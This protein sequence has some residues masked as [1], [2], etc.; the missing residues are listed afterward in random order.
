MSDPDGK[1]QEPMKEKD[2]PYKKPEK[3]EKLS[4][5]E[6]S[7]RQSE[8]TQSPSPDKGPNASSVKEPVVKWRHTMAAEKTMKDM[9]KAAELERRLK[10]KK[11]AD[12]DK[13][14]DKA[15]ES[16]QK[17]DSVLGT[18]SGPPFKES[19]PIGQP[20]E[21]KLLIDPP[22]KEIQP[23]P[24]ADESA[25]FL[26]A[27]SEPKEKDDK[28]K[29][30]PDTKGKRTESPLPKPIEKLLSKPKK[31]K[32]TSEQMPA[33]SDKLESSK[34]E[35]PTKVLRISHTDHRKLKRSSRKRSSTVAV[36]SIE[37]EILNRTDPD[38]EEAI[39]RSIFFSFKIREPLGQYAFFYLAHRCPSP[40]LYFAL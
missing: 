13:Q 29:M 34:E 20:S 36:T 1:I 3:S 35:K 7:R 11:V 30:S 31:Q 24:A 4:L 23:I 33:V 12:A 21:E 10:A 6:A 40:P 27:L 26:D 8:P 19:L 18:A 22:S 16:P 5:S 15:P 28:P 37:K 9:E 38:L 25:H 39:N 14:A 17:E 32:P 2:E